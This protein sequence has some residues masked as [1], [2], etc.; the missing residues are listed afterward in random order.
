MKFLPQLM[1][2]AASSALSSLVLFIGF[3]MLHPNH[4]AS[5]KVMEEKKKIVKGLDHHPMVQTNPYQHLHE[6]RIS[7]LPDEILI[8]I[9]SLVTLKEAGRT[10]ILSKRWKHVWTYVPDLDFNEHSNVS[11]EKVSLENYVRHAIR[12][13]PKFVNWVK[14]VLQS[15]QTLVL[16]KF[17]IYCYFSGSFREELD[18]W[19]QF[20][21]DRRVQ[22]LEVNLSH[23]CIGEFGGED[24]VLPCAYFEQ[25]SWN[26]LKELIF[27]RVYISGGELELLLMNCKNLESLGVHYATELTTLE[28]RGP[29]LALQHLEISYCPLET[30]TISSVNLISL[31]IDRPEALVLKNVSQI[32]HFGIS[33]TCYVIEDIVRRLSCCFSKLE[34]LSLVMGPS[35]VRELG[36]PLQI[37]ASRE[38]ENVVNYPVRH[39]RVVEISQF[40][41]RS[42]EL[43]LIKYFLENASSLRK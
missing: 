29:S 13:R 6:D 8:C 14:K 10:S 25:R 27:T 7:E 35:V 41:G 18:E 21:F 16:N 1:L 42:I 40:R 11:W 32:T 34:V 24:Y 31:K 9:L 17:R 28:I 36:Y 22:R 4:E 26:S 33:S 5:E 3:R 12:E 38:S 20:A 15:H 43:E 2:Y 30:L 37:R 39:L 19:L 23:H